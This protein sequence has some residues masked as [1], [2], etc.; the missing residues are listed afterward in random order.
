MKLVFQPAIF[1]CKLLVSGRV[2]PFFFGWYHKKNETCLAA[3]TLS[4]PGQ[5]RADLWSQWRSERNWGAPFA[6][7]ELGKNCHP[8]TGV[9]FLLPPLGLT[10]FIP[11]FGAVTF[12][13]TCWLVVIWGLPGFFRIRLLGVKKVTKWTFFYIPGQK[14]IGFTCRPFSNVM[15]I[16]V[17]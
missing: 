12:S 1:R 2:E 14:C 6:A 7:W 10:K 4:S 13:T 8:A 3:Y 16:F 11:K 17:V 9:F 15:S 5:G